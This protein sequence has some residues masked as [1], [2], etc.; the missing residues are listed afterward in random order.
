MYLDLV[1]LRSLVELR[2]QGTMVAAAAVL[3]YTTGAISQQ[4]ASLELQVGYPLLVHS[5]RQVELTDAGVV[6]AREAVAILDAE[7]NARE[8][9]AALEERRGGQVRVGVFGTAAAA[10]LPPALTQLRNCFPDI[11]VHSVEVDV[12]AATAAVASHSVDLAFGV[13]YPDAPIPRDPTV[14]LLTL[15]TE[16]FKIALSDL[17]TAPSDAVPLS[18]FAEHGWLLPPERTHYGLAF[19]MACR[20][21]G[22][23][24][25]VNHEVTDTAATLAMAAAG[26]GVAP[27]TDL[28]LQL[29]PRLLESVALV[30]S[31]Q[32]VMVLAHRQHPVLQPGLQ[33]VIEAI[34]QTILNGV[35]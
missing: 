13:D 22:F 9:V 29:R 1:K 11:V 34:Q 24:P 25:Q 32:R 18:H 28:M 3:G 10:L 20:R 7:R 23:E 19:R 30:E 27:V 21:A 16:S 26:M 12:D 6:L 35:A 2:N 4:I 33:S 8:A 14:T 17:E 31:I 5:G 15:R